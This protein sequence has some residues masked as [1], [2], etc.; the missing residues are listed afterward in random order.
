MKLAF[1]HWRI[2]LL[3]KQQHKLIEYRGYEASYR[4][5]LR[6]GFKRF[7]RSLRGMKIMRE[8]E[9]I[10]DRIYYNKHI[11]NIWGAWK[12]GIQMSR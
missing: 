11:E 9:N 8:K 3:T 7:Q 1:G 2:Y 10:A 4:V 6:M 5:G 12:L